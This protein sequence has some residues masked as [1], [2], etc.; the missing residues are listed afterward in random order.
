M[1]TTGG[2]SAL[3]HT[4]AVSSPERKK[5]KKKKKT[6]H[7]PYIHSSKH[8]PRPHENV[9]GCKKSLFYDKKVNMD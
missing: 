5:S 8:L 9:L 1:I 3:T 4:S 2:K 6:L 7:R